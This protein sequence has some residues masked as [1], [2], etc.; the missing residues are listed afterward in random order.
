MLRDSVACRLR[1]ARSEAGYLFP[2]YD[3]Y[4]FANVQGTTFSVLGES[5]GR[6]L[7]EDVLEGIDDDVDRVLVVLL[8]GLG[9]EQWK[10]HRRERP[11]LA[12]LSERGR[13]TPLISTY[14]S[15]TAAAMTTFAT[16]LLPV[17]HGVLGWYQY[18][19]A[20]DAVVQTLPFATVDGRPVDE[21]FE[22]ASRDLLFPTTS[23]YER[24]AARGIDVHLAQPEGILDPRDPALLAAGI[25]P[26]PY[27]T[28]GGMAI[29]LRRTLEA[30]SAGDR[31]YVHAYVPAI[32]AAAHAAGTDSSEYRATLSNVSD[33]LR[34]ELIDR[35][36]RETAARTLLLVVADHGHVDTDPATNVDLSR[37]DGIREHL[38]TDRERPADPAGWRTAQSPVSRRDGPRTDGPR[39]ART[40]VRRAGVRPDGG[41]R[42]GAV[43]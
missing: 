15:E 25:E 20:L 5:L 39:R 6:P 13:V 24:A 33:R 21:A 9:Y 12:A 41:A 14:P 22:G 19:E 30:A 11:F 38:R 7:P 31:T 27:R 3:E 17:E 26:L 10:R 36:D 1:D 29:R 42:S 23:L 34:A 37:V 43:R 40:R 16:G 28:I 35:L 18:V 2:A 8:D 32:D 4:C